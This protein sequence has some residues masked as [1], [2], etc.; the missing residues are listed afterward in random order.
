VKRYLSSF[1]FVS[2]LIA[3]AITKTESIKQ[4]IITPQAGTLC[5]IV[6]SARDCTYITIQIDQS[7]SAGCEIYSINIPYLVDLLIWE[8]L[9][10]HDLLVGYFTNGKETVSLIFNSNNEFILTPCNQLCLR[11]CFEY[12]NPITR[13]FDQLNVRRCM[14]VGGDLIVCGKIITDPVCLVTPCATQIER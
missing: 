10:Q 14:R 9:S 1:F 7:Q 12:A 11:S 8:F 6:N 3:S 4:L 2:L 5:G 13:T